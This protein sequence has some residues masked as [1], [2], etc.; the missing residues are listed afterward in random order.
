MVLL[1]VLGGGKINNEVEFVE[2]EACGGLSF[3][4]F[5]FWDFLLPL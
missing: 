2:E 5:S 1:S 4:F 3:L